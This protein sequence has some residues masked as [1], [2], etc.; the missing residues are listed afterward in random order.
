MS[1]ISYSKNA[2]EA[3]LDIWGGGGRKKEIAHCEAF[4]GALL[5][6]SAFFRV[7]NFLVSRTPWAGA[8]GEI[9]MRGGVLFLKKRDY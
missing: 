3:S 5:Q 6:I 8:A 1:Q 4:T 7:R 9:I 2:P